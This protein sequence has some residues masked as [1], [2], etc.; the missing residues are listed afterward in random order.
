MWTHVLGYSDALALQL[1]LA[2]LGSVFLQNMTAPSNADLVRLRQKLDTFG[3]DHARN[4]NGNWSW[5]QPPTRESLVQHLLGSPHFHVNL[6]P[7][8]PFDEAI[9]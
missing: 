5:P 7:E 9:K 8:L 4:T 6:R 1:I 2:V 3:H